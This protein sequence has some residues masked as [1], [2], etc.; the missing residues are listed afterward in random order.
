M[1]V[2]VSS[3]WGF[4]AA[5]FSLILLGL[6]TGFSPVLYAAQASFIAHPKTARRSMRALIYGVI[7]GTV[8]LGLFFLLFQV[9][10]LTDLLN[11]ALQ[12]LIISALIQFTIGAMLITVGVGLLKKAHRKEYFTNPLR[13][14]PT[15]TWGIIGFAAI[16]TLFSA[17]GAASTFV[18]SG[19][20]KSA[21]AAVIGE[22]ILAA[23]FI[24]AVIAPF[25]AVYL[26][27]RTSPSHFEAIAD[28]LK[29][30]FRRLRYQAILA[31]AFIILGTGVVAF[32]VI[33]RGVAFLQLYI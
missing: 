27:W 23:V 7:L 20:V 4:V 13:N 31:T 14:N 25:V 18:A 33:S 26:I 1:E 8:V 16:K 10:I 11:S 24:A 29:K 3:V 9:S 5:L 17:G 19:I 6:I 32:T 12:A 15:G 28:S 30:R 2:I 22:L 21:G